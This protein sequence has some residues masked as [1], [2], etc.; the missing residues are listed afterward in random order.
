MKTYVRAVHNRSMAGDTD[1]PELLICILGPPGGS[2]FSGHA[3]GVSRHGMFGSAGSAEMNALLSSPLSSPKTVLR[4]EP[5]LISPAPTN[6][7]E[8]RR[9]RPTNQIT[10]DP[11]ENAASRSFRCLEQSHRGA[12]GGSRSNTQWCL[13]PLS[14]PVGVPG[15]RPL[16]G[17][18]R[19]DNPP[20]DGRLVSVSQNPLRV[21]IAEDE[22]LIRLHLKE[23][24]EE[25]GYS[26]VAEA[27]DGESAVEHVTTLRPDLAILDIKIPVL[28]ATSSR[29]ADRR[30]VDP[31]VV[32]LT[33]FPSASWWSLPATWPCVP[34][35]A[36][37]QG[38]PGA[39]HPDGG[40]PVRRDPRR[41]TPSGT[42]R[43]R[44][45]VRS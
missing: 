34:G 1:N 4:P 25:E 27:A 7:P 26:V 15:R 14:L 38:R 20:D 36:V 22:A 35:Q 19:D 16:Q 21:V 42:L 37:H 40:Q 43:E 10:E 28:D 41:S 6:Q 45:E 29:R 31:P 12:P 24:P 33:A 9:T 30:R 8:H 23:M 2:Q 32:I 18:Q 11:A 39:G 44:L 3:D 5:T 17:E 13:R